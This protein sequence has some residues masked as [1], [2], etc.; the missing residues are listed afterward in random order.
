[1]YG[2]TN[3]TERRGDEDKEAFLANLGGPRAPSSPQYEAKV[4]ETTTPT[5]KEQIL[6]ILNYCAASIMMTVVN[7]V[8]V[9]SLRFPASGLRHV[10]PSYAYS[11]D[12]VG[13]HA[14]AHTT[15]TRA[16]GNVA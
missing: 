7:K 16:R 14:G 3:A 2:N 9:V 11:N 1:M 12:P 13:I 8:C 6:P 4:A 10:T 15:Q 5:G